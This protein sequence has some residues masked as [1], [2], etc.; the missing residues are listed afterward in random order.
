[1]TD[2]LTFPHFEPHFPR[3]RWSLPNVLEHQAEVRADRPCLSW[4]DAG[5]AYS[6]AEVNAIANR[7]ARGFQSKGVKKGDYVVIFLPNCLEY[8][9]SWY[10]LAKLGA[11]EVTVGDS[12]KGAFLRHQANLSKSSIIVTT[13]ELAERLIEI[14]EELVHIEHCILVS[15]NDAEPLPAFSRITTSRFSDLYADDASNLGIPVGPRDAAA[16]LFTSGTTGLSKGVLMSHSHFYFFAEEDLQLVRL[17]ENDVYSTSF[18]LFHGNAQFLT[19]YPSLLAGAHCVLYTRFSASDFIGRIRRSGSTVCNLL[20]ATMAF[21]L[22]QPPRPDD[23]DH[24]LTRIYA[25]PLAPDLGAKFVD[26]FGDITFVDGF[27]QT[28]ISNI[29]QTPWQA[30]RPAGASGVLVDQFFEVRLAD[31][32][33]GEEVAEGEI[34]E[35][36]IRPK[37]PGIVC[38]E[39]LGMPEKTVEAWKD[40][41][42]HTGD[43]LRRDERGW[44]FFVDRVKDAL[45]R[46]GENISS[47][48]VESVVR[49]HHAVAECAVVAAKA[50]EEG[51]EDEVK[52]FIVLNDGV[53]LDYDDLAAWCDAKMPSFMV[54]RFVEVIEALPQTPSQKVQKKELRERG[55]GPATWDRTR[56]PAFA[57]KA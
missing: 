32:E 36:L 16:V 28:E 52:V 6:F 27:G 12:Y 4:T 37:I 34:G 50:D 14:E 51:S 11:V 53:E 18:P 35:L 24:K 26:R 33:T 49:S 55:N 43:A 23:K 13:P 56:Q 48:E 57:R 22:A 2:V 42:F 38:M 46:R 7:L 25:A 1:M 8:V 31:P 20:G 15:E 47:F 5:K 3:D 41:W 9:F 44:Y 45:R 17:T 29:F 39:Y 19:V 30:E 10:A 21:I 40:L 54:P